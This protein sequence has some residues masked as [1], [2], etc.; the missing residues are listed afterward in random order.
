VA[1]GGPALIRLTK[2]LTYPLVALASCPSSS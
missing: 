1:A 2:L